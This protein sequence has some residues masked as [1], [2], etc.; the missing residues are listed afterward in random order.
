MPRYCRSCSASV[1][2]FA[3]SLAETGERSVWTAQDSVN[4]I[5][6]R[7]S[8]GQTVTSCFNYRR[9]TPAM[10]PGPA[11]ARRCWPPW[12]TI[13]GRTRTAFSQLSG[14]MCQSQRYVDAHR[15]DPP[16]RT[17]AQMGGLPPMHLI[18]L[19]TAAAA[20]N[21]TVGVAQ[22][23]FPPRWTSAASPSTPQGHTE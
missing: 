10:T 14:Q 7:W 19:P 9:S 16:G 23:A 11:Q 2:A 17:T 5:V 3:R 15:H 22:R 1:K 8:S 12:W 20:G 21:P 4:A 18:T 13:R 6:R